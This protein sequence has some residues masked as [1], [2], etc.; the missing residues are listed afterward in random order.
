M[1]E[2]V[3]AGSDEEGFLGNYPETASLVS[4][5]AEE[6]VWRVRTVPRELGRSVSRFSSTPSTP[7][8][9]RSKF[10]LTHFQNGLKQGSEES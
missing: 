3:S 6:E 4:E 9:T 2:D 5:E 7:L 8:E 10:L 1:V